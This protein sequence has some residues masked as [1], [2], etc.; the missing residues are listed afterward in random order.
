MKFRRYFFRL[1]FAIFGLLGFAWA[2]G[3]LYFDGPSPWFAWTLAV[4]VG[5]GVFFMDSWVR[6]LGVIG[7]FWGV[8]LGWWV[9]IQPSNV[10]NWQAD[11][12]QTSWAEIEGDDVTIHNLRNFEYRTAADYTPVWE[13]RKVRLSEVTG[14]D[15]FINYWGSPWMAHPIASFQFAQGP[16]VCFSI[17]TRKKVGQSY[18]AIGG[19]YR[20][21]ELIY[22]VADERDVVRLRTKYRK[23]EEAYL[24]RIAISPAAARGRFLEYLSSLNQLHEVPRWYNAITTNCTTGIRNQHPTAERQPWDW[25][26]LVNG[27]GDELT[28]EFGGFR[29]DGLSFAE[30]KRRALIQSVTEEAHDSRDFSKLIREGRPGFGSAQGSAV[31]AVN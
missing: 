9:T 18:S 11:V 21:Y 22:I 24:Y 29:T 7:L 10:A 19:I 2:V 16:P 27:K 6:K 8:V 31:G 12:A 20:Q 28:Y 17:E 1:L 30:L 25:R 5:L 15:L 26:M 13:T 14:V 4:A 3:A 23:G